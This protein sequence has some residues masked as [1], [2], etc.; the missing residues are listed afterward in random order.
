MAKAKNI[1]TTKRPAAKRTAGKAQKDR[2]SKAASSLSKA[3]FGHRSTA[4]DLYTRAF[5]EGFIPGGGLG[6][7]GRARKV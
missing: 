2:V 5:E 6:L 1:S 3:S 7:Y 4:P